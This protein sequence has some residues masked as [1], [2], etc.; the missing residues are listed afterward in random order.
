M[1]KSK[2]IYNLLKL[3]AVIL[4]YFPASEGSAQNPVTA[5]DSFNIRNY[6]EE[7]YVQADR[8]I[9]FT[10]EQVWMKVMTMERLT[11]EPAS[12]SHVVYLEM[13]DGTNNIIG[14]AKVNVKDSWGDCSLRL[15]DTLKTGNY[16]IRAYSAW[17]RN[18]TPDRFFYRYISIINPYKG[19]ADL[20]RRPS[21]GETDTVLFY[22]EGGK[23]ITGVENRMA[24]KSFDSEGCP[25][26]AKGEVITGDGSILVSAGTDDK[27]FG[28]VS[29]VPPRNTTLFFRC[30]GRTNKEK[31]KIIRINGI[32][33]EGIS[34][35]VDAPVENQS[36]I[37]RVIGSDS[38]VRTGE[39]GRL[40][41]ITGGVISLTR[42]FRFG[43]DTLLKIPADE[44]PDGISGLILT[45][46][47]G[48][49]LARRWIFRNDGRKLNISAS[50]GSS[51]FAPRQKVSLDISSPDFGG[52]PL[53]TWM[54]VSVV[55]TSLVFSDRE[56][57]GSRRNLI[58]NSNDWQSE[59][60]QKQFNEQLLCHDD[61]IVF[62][63]TGR[64]LPDTLAHQP[65]LE[66]EILRG[67]MKS[68][69]SGNPLGNTDISLAFV[70]KSARCQF[71][72]TDSI[73]RFSFV[74]NEKG[75]V[76]IVIQPAIPDNSGYFVELAEPFSSSFGDPVPPPFSLD[77][78]MAEKLNRA[79]IAMQVKTIYEPFAGKQ[80]TTPPESKGGDFY[81]AP[82]KIINLSDYIELKNIREVVKE[83]IPELFV[84]KRNKKQVFKLINNYPY[85]PFENRALVL[86]DGVP[87]YDISKLLE[88]RS[89]DFER[90]DIFNRR[91]FYSD[92]VF[93]G[94]VSFVTKKGDLSAL[95]S[96]SDIFRQ[97]FEGYHDPG[98]FY[99]PDYTLKEQSRSR[100]PDFRNTLYWKPDLMPGNDGKA[101]VSFFTSDEPGEYTVIME[102]ITADGKTGVCRITF[103]VI[104]R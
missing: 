97:V 93:D 26:S 16:I 69:S 40:Q 51:Q 58:I 66:G 11:G 83:I 47:N 45:D 34:F 81:G 22:P 41:M 28:L 71:T 70:G 8:D 65:E 63:N 64:I 32:N 18:Y 7:V 35:S 77:T 50:L 90:I 86:V 73:G 59:Y 88:A 30:S 87:L 42:E 43:L 10:G 79:V 49:T 25:V 38:K 55:R 98:V 36:F 84:V 60:R 57:I 68:R 101:S 102:G 14:Q 4:L 103:D 15:P 20:L 95:E 17:M 61:P 85:Q 89:R 27:G 72:R 104:S 76:E 96:S 74:L 100:I 94:I 80:I 78:I 99:S 44:I 52:L 23:L 13:L 46:E 75:L 62:L 33:S 12:L 24:L 53:R 56:D 9:Y 48:N 21:S 91:Y 5:T 1:M 31:S 37:I 29:F 2:N 3:Q 6:S 19:F 54:T 92:W 82:D 39:T 67:V